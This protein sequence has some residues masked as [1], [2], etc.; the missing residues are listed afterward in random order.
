METFVNLLG[1]RFGRLT[2][3]E[4]MPNNA[5]HQAVWRCRCDCGN[6]VVV[7]SG[8]LRSGHTQ[9]CGCLCREKAAEYQY[10]HGM[11]GTK[12]FSVF[13]TMKD[14]CYNPNSKK[15]KDYGARGIRICDEWLNSSALFFEWAKENGY[16]EGLSIDRIDVNGNYEPSNCRWVDAK[17]Q[18]NNK[19]YNH[20]YEYNG[21]IQTISQWAD[22]LG[23]PYAT[24]KCRIKRG[25]F[26]ELFNVKDGGVHLI[27]YKGVSLSIKDWAELLGVNYS[28]M[29][30]RVRR[31]NFEKF[32]PKDF[33]KKI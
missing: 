29:R 13:H 25:S 17:F 14:R 27:T 5:K 1:Q 6:E 21:K 26:D 24:I 12:L 23:L 33:K 9:S 3:M 19:R 7:A 20:L 30:A 28:T 32:M 16:Q 4:R 18:A 15:Y 10:R 31:G 2:V 11:K 22:E 8:H